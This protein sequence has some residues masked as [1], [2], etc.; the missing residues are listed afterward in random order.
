MK[1]M[2][3]VFAK[4]GYGALWRMDGKPWHLQKPPLDDP[5]LSTYDFPNAEKFVAPILENKQKAID[6][7]ITDTEH[8]RLINMGWG[9]F[10]HTWRIRGFENALMDT[11]ADEDFYGELAKK[12]I[13]CVSG[14][15]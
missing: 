10:E 14:T 7:Y 12:G 13:V 6:A 3:D 1:P 8:F 9:V 15:G 5:D 11:V 2:D 4:D